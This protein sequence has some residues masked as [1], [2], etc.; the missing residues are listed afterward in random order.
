M[1]IRRVIALLLAAWAFVAPAKEPAVPGEAPAM[2][3]AVPAAREA[4]EEKAQDHVLALRAEGEKFR[5]AMNGLVAELGGELAVA[6]MMM[7]PGTGAAEVAAAVTSR[8]ARA[9][10]LMDNEAIRLY[11][12][13]Q[14]AWK[15]SAPPPPAVALSA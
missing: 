11:A 9:V 10:V 2:D 14:K 12:A 8:R 4:T 13:V 15:D 3:T 5:E 6:E 7:K 1:E